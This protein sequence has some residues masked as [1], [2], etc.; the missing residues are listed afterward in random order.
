[1]EAAHRELANR[2][3][4]AACR[5]FGACTKVFTGAGIAAGLEPPLPR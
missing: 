3:E 5:R 4:W 2:L 1:M